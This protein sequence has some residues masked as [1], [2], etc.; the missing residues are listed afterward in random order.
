M[1]RLHTRSANYL[2]NVFVFVSSPVVQM[3][4]RTH[5]MYSVLHHAM[6]SAHCNAQSGCYPGCSANWDENMCY[7]ILPHPVTLFS[8]FSCLKGSRD[9]FFPPLFWSPLNVAT[10]N[11]RCYQV[12]LGHHSFFEVL[13]IW[14][15]DGM[16]MKVATF[17]TIF[18][19]GEQSLRLS[20]GCQPLYKYP[21]CTSSKCL[22]QDKNWQQ[23]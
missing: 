11:E 9:F 22:P 5:C 23:T 8:M 20:K 10:F 2:T 18:P 14:C 1:R 12:L 19:L 3:Y 17:W 13:L 4:C 21:S 6:F 7:V 16:I 15:L